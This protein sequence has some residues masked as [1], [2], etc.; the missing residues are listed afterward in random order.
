MHEINQIYVLITAHNTI[1]WEY[2]KWISDEYPDVIVRHRG[3]FH[4]LSRGLS[5]LARP[6]AVSMVV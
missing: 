1:L 2:T 4:C 3:M 5:P 6:E